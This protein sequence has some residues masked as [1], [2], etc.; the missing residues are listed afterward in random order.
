MERTLGR[1]AAD[2]VRPATAGLEVMKAGRS[3]RVEVRHAD[4]ATDPS[5]FAAHAPDLV[6]AAALFDLVSEQWIGSFAAALAAARVPLYAVL[7]Y[8]G[9]NSWSPPHPADTAM[10]AAFNRHQ[11]ND[12]GFGSAAGSRA[13]ELL[14]QRLAAASY[15]VER[16]PSPWRLGA[17]ETELIRV[18]TQGFAEAVR[19]TGEVPAATIEAWLRARMADGVTCTVGHDDILAIPR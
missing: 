13:T 9:T 18:L 3:I 4:L 17:G 11:G 2:Q 10:I 16:A 15:R 7:D 12:K 19:E 1:E 14:A 8:D 5:A 6:T